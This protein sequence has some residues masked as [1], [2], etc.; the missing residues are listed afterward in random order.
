M[1]HEPACLRETTRERDLH[2]YSQFLNFCS[3]VFHGCEEGEPKI[4]I[5]T[6][7]FSKVSYIS[8]E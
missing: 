1:K 4:L 8:F 5:S 6:A 3:A 2:F 7:V